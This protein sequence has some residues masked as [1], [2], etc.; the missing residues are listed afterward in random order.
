M[1]AYLSQLSPLAWVGVS[2]PLMILARAILNVAVPTVIRIVLPD[3]VRAVLH[4]L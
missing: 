4:F 2:I 1:K 3:S